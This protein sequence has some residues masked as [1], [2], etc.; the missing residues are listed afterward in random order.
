MQ[1]KKL[2]QRVPV[3]T[4]LNQSDAKQ[5]ARQLPK[6]AIVRDPLQRIVSAWRDKFG[7]ID[8]AGN[9]N[10]K[11]IFYV[12]FLYLL[13]PFFL[14]FHKLQI[15][16]NVIGKDILQHYRGENHTQFNGLEETITLEEFFRFINDNSNEANQFNMH[17]RPFIYNGCGFCKFP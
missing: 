10:D 4:S 5:I 12:I 3:L 7:P 14:N 2:F 9:V 6:V 17:W 1:T 11:R 13:L 15:M 16:Q 8:L